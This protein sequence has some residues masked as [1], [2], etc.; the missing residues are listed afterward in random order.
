[1]DVGKDSPS[2]SPEENIAVKVENIAVKV[3]DEGESGSDIIIEDEKFASRSSSPDIEVVKVLKS[4]TRITVD[5]TGDDDDDTAVICDSLEQSEA[6]AA[7]VVD[8][9]NEE[10]GYCEPSRVHLHL[11]REYVDNSS[12]TFL[13]PN[14]DNT[15]YTHSQLQHQ[16]A[17]DFGNG[18]ECLFV[19]FSHLQ[20][21]F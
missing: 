7:P 17:A 3:E 6:S 8:L 11:E 2:P 4:A 5:L 15:S 20:F 9:S 18:S 12:F 16:S 13:P 1:M 19:I 10:N 21:S 14:T